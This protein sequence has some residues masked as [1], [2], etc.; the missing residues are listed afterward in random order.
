M[1][2]DGESFRAGLDYWSGLWDERVD[3]ES[4]GPRLSR[5]AFKVASGTV[6]D[7]FSVFRT[8]SPAA[9][10]KWLRI[11]KHVSPVRDS[12][13]D[14]RLVFLDFDVNDLDVSFLA[15]LIAA[16]EVA[17]EHIDDDGDLVTTRQI[18]G[19]LR[20]IGRANLV[21]VVIGT[22]NLV[23]VEFDEHDALILEALAIRGLSIIG[24]IS[25]QVIDSDTYVDCYFYFPQTD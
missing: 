12:P 23:S 1:Y 8:G 10:P 24:E 9:I 19:W 14:S 7:L 11:P 5:D 17:D 15:L 13:V 2:P 3:P 18:E 25:I 20:P 22:V 4:L 21:D 6:R 16:L